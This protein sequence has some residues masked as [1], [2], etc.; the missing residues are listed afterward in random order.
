MLS[1]PFKIEQNNSFPRSVF[2]ISHQL[3]INCELTFVKIVRTVITML[4]KRPL[5]WLNNW[6]GQSRWPLDSAICCL[7]LGSSHALG[8]SGDWGGHHGCRFSGERGPTF[9]GSRRVWKSWFGTPLCCSPSFPEVSS[10]P[11][12]FLPSVNQG[13]FPL[14]RE[15]AEVFLIESLHLWCQQGRE[16]MGIHLFLLPGGLEAL[17]LFYTWV[18]PG[19][20]W[21]PWVLCFTLR[22]LQHSLGDKHE[23]RHI[24]DSFI[25]LTYFILKV[26]KL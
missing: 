5:K 3:K 13:H 26:G 16:W 17:S 19:V 9:Q 25:C 12:S 22:G 20:R 7:L 2:C 21:H 15:K 23:S 8:H 1:L 14:L 18:K 24:L 4:D 10:S 6:E 11:E